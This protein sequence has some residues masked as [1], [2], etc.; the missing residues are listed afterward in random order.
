VIVRILPE[1]EE[2]LYQAV[3]W[4]EDREPGVGIRMLV[5]YDETRRRINERADR[6]PRLETMPPGR[7]I[8]RSFLRR[9][10]YMVVFEMLPHEVVI[11]AV[12]HSSRKPHYWSRRVS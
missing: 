9:F 3:L 12:A 4:Y 2:D 5:A 8:R 11:I 6:L 1:A 10:P 7:D